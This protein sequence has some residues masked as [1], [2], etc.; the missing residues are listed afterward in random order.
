MN[1]EEGIHGRQQIHAGCW[2]DWDQQGVWQHRHFIPLPFR[3]FQILS[4][5]AEH[6]E[7]VVSQA[8]LF[9]VG[10][11]ESRTLWDLQ[12]HIHRIRM[13]IESD[14]HHPQWLVTRRDGGYVLHLEKAS[15]HA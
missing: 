3:T 4:Y 9:S 13:A 11:G 5:L 6:S 1:R 15:K 10:W 8:A 14:L 2:I 12:I 7:H